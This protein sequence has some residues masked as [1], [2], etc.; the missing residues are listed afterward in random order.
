MLFMA[1]SLLLFYIFFNSKV[2]W[3]GPT[4]FFLFF[5]LNDPF[6]VSKVPF[7]CWKVLVIKENCFRNVVSSFQNLKCHTFFFI[8]VLGWSGKRDRAV[9]ATLRQLDKRRLGNC[10][11]IKS[12]GL[13]HLQGRSKDCRTNDQQGRRSVK[14]LI[15][16]N[17]NK[18]I[19]LRSEVSYHQVSPSKLSFGF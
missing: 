1:F 2:F 11:L 9:V 14:Y 7:R 13:W 16:A 15:N 10:H 18:C 6:F 19:K 5:F 4:N 12:I 17:A 3:W 8:S